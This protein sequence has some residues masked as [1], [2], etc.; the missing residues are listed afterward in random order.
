VSD[1]KEILKREAERLARASS[2]V[3]VTFWR[4]AVGKN[5]VRILPHWSG[6]KNKVFYKKAKVHFGVG[7]DKQ[8]VVCRKVSPTDRCPVCDYVADLDATG[9]REDAYLARDLSAKERFA[10]NIIDIK[11][12]KA[13][14]QVWEMGRG[15]F[16]DII[17]LFTDEEYGDLDDLDTGRHITIH[18]T[19]EGRTDTRYRVIPSSVVT[20]VSH[21]VLEKLND[22]DTLYPIPSIDEV[23]AILYGDDYYNSTE[24]E[25][26]LLVDEGEDVGEPESEEEGDLEDVVV[27]EEA[28]KDEDEE[29]ILEIPLGDEEEAPA[30]KPKPESRQERLKKM[31]EAVKAKEAG[32]ARRRK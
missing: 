18:R 10:V 4:P 25:S 9:R 22:L 3:G 8:R 12:P 15:L 27:E 28:G 1:R 11:D 21:K 19:G 16:N 2:T 30:A 29:E 13:G 31:R 32:A 24:D 17:L 6:D 23:N 7:P 20:K 14:I 5:V 26:E